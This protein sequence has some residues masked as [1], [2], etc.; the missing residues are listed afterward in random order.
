MSKTNKLSHYFS[1]EIFDTSK[2]EIWSLFGA[3]VIRNKREW[4]CFFFP[5]H[6]CESETSLAERNSFHFE[7]RIAPHAKLFLKAIYGK[8]L[9]QSTACQG[10]LFEGWTECRA[11]SFSFFFFLHIWLLAHDENRW[12]LIWI[13]K[14]IIEMHLK[15]LLSWVSF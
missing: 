4:I 13:Y 11:F 2:P 5:L 1:Y 7:F 6:L 8:P 10:W 12:R 14:K 3:P 15:K 9:R